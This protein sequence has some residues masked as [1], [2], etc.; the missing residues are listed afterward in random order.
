MGT[1]RVPRPI[2]QATLDALAA[3]AVRAEAAP[4]AADERWIATHPNARKRAVARGQGHPLSL[5]SRYQL[6]FRVLRHYVG[7]FNW[8]QGQM[9]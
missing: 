2:R 1:S 8:F 6:N 9:A 7:S 5:S 4:G 3:A